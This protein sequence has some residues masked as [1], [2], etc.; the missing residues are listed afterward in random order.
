MGGSISPIN[1]K[2]FP[3]AFFPVALCFYETL[4][5]EIC[6]GRFSFILVRVLVLGWGFFSDL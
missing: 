6:M 1:I 3:H 2:L 5:Y 4:H